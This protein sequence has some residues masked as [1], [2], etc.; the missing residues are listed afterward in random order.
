M[1]RH[2]AA[3]SSPATTGEGEDGVESAGICEMGVGMPADRNSPTPGSRSVLGS[4][5][6]TPCSRL[7]CEISG[8]G[9]VYELSSAAQSLESFVSHIEL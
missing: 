5:A 6:T 3:S 7:L 4:T 9:P 8:T 2:A 1:L